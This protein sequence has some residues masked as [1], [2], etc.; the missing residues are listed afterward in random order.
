MEDHF[1]VAPSPCKLSSLIPVPDEQVARPRFAG[2]MIAISQGDSQSHV[3]SRHPTPPW[4]D[5]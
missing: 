4:H 3:D 5:Y 1:E 2:P